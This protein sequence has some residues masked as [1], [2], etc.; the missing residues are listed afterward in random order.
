MGRVYS[1]SETV[2]AVSEPP[3]VRP[4]NLLKET[5]AQVFSCESCEIYNNTFFAEHLWATTSVL[6]K[7]VSGEIKESL[8]TEE[9]KK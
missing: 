4:A 7:N 1:C 8:S 9:F 5:P 2:K 6:W 3:E